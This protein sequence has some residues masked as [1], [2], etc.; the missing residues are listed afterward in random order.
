MVGRRKEEQGAMALL[1][2]TCTL[3]EQSATL[4]EQSIA[5]SLKTV[6]RYL[7]KCLK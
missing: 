7:E 1:D 5:T 6:G 3:I 4:I 2:N